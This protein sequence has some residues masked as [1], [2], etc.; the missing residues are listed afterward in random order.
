MN[1]QRPNS[2]NRPLIAA[3]AQDNELLDYVQNL[4]PAFIQQLSQ[5]S[6]EV[7]K[8][9]EGNIVGMLGGL[10]GEAFPTTITTSKEALG[11]LLA[12]AMMNGYF[13]RNAEQRLQME[14]SIMPTDEASS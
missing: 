5:P 6:P 11:Q 8:M 1:N 9:I 4:D 2:A 7:I 12:S 10:P 14:K 3:H 13:L